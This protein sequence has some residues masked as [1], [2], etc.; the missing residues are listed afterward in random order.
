MNN[1]HICSNFW[2]ATSQR[3]YTDLL[4]DQGDQVLKKHYNT[5]AGLMEMTQDEEVQ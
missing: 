1:R 4:A 5:S 3:C 2:E